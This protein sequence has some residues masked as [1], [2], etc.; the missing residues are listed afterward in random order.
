[1]KKAIAH[2]H[3]MQRSLA[4]K[5][6]KLKQLLGFESCG[7]KGEKGSKAGAASSREKSSAL[8]SIK[9]A[10]EKP[11]TPRPR[12][13]EEP[14]PTVA[15]SVTGLESFDD[16]SESHTSSVKPEP[17]LA[18]QLKAAQQK[19][20]ELQKELEESREAQA[21]MCEA[22]VTLAKSL[23]DSMTRD[24]ELWQR[25][26]D[27]DKNRATLR[28][29][30]KESQDAFDRLQEENSGLFTECQS[31]REANKCLHQSQR[32]AIETIRALEKENQA[33]RPFVEVNRSLREMQREAIEAMRTLQEENQAL[34]P[35]REMNHSLRGLLR[36]SV[37]RLMVLD[38]EKQTLGQF[39]EK[40]V[41]ERDDAEKLQEQL[42]RSLYE[43]KKSASRMKDGVAKLYAESAHFS[44][45]LEKSS[46]ST[47]E[48]TKSQDTSTS[49][50]RVGG[51]EDDFLAEIMAFA[52]SQ[53]AL[54]FSFDQD[55]ALAKPSASRP[56][57]ATKD[58]LPVAAS[59][60][61][62][63]QQHGGV[64]HTPERGQ[65]ALP[66]GYF[67]VPSEMREG[68]F[69]YN[70]D[71]HS[72][73]KTESQLMGS[74]VTSSAQTHEESEPHAPTAA[75]EPDSPTEWADSRSQDSGSQVERNPEDP[76]DD[77]ASS[78]QSI[79]KPLLSTQSNPQQRSSLQRALRSE[80]PKLLIGKDSVETVYSKQG[81]MDSSSSTTRTAN[82]AGRRM[83]SFAA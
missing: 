36:Q 13:V 10:N 74:H 21:S 56:R 42:K 59:D 54:T 60:K 37:E 25:Q 17:D 50:S 80:T 77:A 49:E 9:E 40:V 2:N 1:M 51:Q 18:L 79:S 47:A 58:F 30:L 12:T 46:V 71:V 8:P 65:H 69:K 48:E 67:V 73:A 75:R 63:Q 27:S 61:P 19:I 64:W 14:S 43:A 83:V 35:F 68:E 23:E 41:R 62:L 4:K 78:P 15:T 26:T 24:Q 38:A 6:K 52:E 32:E 20:E 34:Q 76:R 70:E 72:E 5:R 3:D 53:N 31:F 45:A 66:S 81:S 29:S 22:N 11:A 28:Q 39:A 33:L 55:D 82:S 7:G 57:G 44:D 16:S